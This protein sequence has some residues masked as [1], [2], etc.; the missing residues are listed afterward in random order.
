MLT[1]RLHMVLILME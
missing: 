1:L